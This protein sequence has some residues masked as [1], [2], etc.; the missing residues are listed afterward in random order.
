[1]RR[2]RAQLYFL[3]LFV[4]R[5]LILQRILPIFWLPVALRRN[6]FRGFD[7]SHAFPRDGADFLLGAEHLFLT[8]H[9]A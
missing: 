6:D 5:S 3:G 7:G 8:G 2:A 1:M 4:A 9:F